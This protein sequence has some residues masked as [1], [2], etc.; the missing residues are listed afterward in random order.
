MSG[1]LLLISGPAGV[2]KT[3]LCNRLLE[4]FSSSLQRV[5]TATS[6]KPR[7]SEVDGV[8]YFFFTE[9]EFLEKVKSQEFLEYEIIHGC[10]YGTLDDRNC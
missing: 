8:D 3:T 5:I 6:R 4:E 7:Y 2:G 1:H 9:E 10:Y